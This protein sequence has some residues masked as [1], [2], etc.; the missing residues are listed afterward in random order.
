MLSN[1]DD[2]HYATLK[3]KKENID[4]N[5]D[6]HKYFTIRPTRVNCCGAKRR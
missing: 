1:Y 3:E 4:E 2:N 5:K 6:A